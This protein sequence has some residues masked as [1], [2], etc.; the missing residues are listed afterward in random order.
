LKIDAISK[1]A[2]AMLASVMNAIPAILAAS[3]ILIVFVI[4]AKFVS[5]ALKN[6]FESLNFDEFPAKIG[7]DKAMG[8]TT[9]STVASK[10]IF[11][12][13]C[14]FGLITAFEKL[15]FIRIVDLLND[16]LALSGKIFFGLA[17]M[18]LGSFLSNIAYKALSGSV[19][20]LASIAK[21]ALLGLFF[22]MALNSMGFA[23]DI[24]NLAFALI[25]GAIAV[26]V[27]LS[28]GLGGREAAGK[29]MQKILDKFNS[30]D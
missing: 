11:F 13:I 24:V 8:G 3:I 10:V 7:L 19:N 21:I 5:T 30:K 25:L 6:L 23:E 14:F 28:F 20:G 1:P 17:I 27:A 26:A 18:A 29:Q 15:G 9:V 4:I 16:M 22:A 12:Y 2:T